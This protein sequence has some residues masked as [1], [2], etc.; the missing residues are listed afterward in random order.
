MLKLPLILKKNYE[1]TL[2]KMISATIFVFLVSRL[3]QFQLI[4]KLKRID[5]FLVENV[6]HRI[7]ICI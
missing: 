4:Q 7:Q 1:K 2:S 6:N 3:K 5:I